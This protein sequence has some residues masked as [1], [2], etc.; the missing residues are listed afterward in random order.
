MSPVLPRDEHGAVVTVGTFDGVH[1]GHHAVLTEIAARA[2]RTGRRSVLVTFEPHPLRVVRPEAAPPLLTS[3]DEKKELLAQ[4]GLDYVVF[5]PFTR[6]LQMYSARRFV[7]EILRARIGMRE[8]VIGY[9]HGFGRGREGGVETLRALGEELGFAV[10]VVG[11]VADDE[12]AVSS[13]RIRRALL[14]GDVTAAAEGLGRPYQVRGTVVPGDGRGRQI[15]FPTANL[16]LSDPDKLL[17]REGIYAVWC[18]VGGER[19]AGVLHVG[20]R[21]TF[22]GAGPTVEVHLL[23][24][25]GELYGRELAVE[26]CAWLRPIE[27]FDSVAE[28]TA[29]IA[30]DVEAGRAALQPPG[31]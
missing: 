24:F 14:A 27:K 11:P 20:P 7:E 22:P 12:A 31:A 29:A 1:R 28:L 21:P 19:V 25:R 9:D 23:D 4:S 10:D 30:A 6:A 17:P 5:L 26:F 2:A 16:R 18:S 13:T 8:L 15:G 3:R